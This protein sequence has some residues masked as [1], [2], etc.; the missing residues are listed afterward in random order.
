[1]ELLAELWSP[2]SHGALPGALRLL[3]FR[4]APRLREPSVLRIDGA[5][6]SN[7][8][9][10]RPWLQ[11]VLPMLKSTRRLRLTLGFGA[12]IRALE[13]RLT[14]LRAQPPAETDASSPGDIARTAARLLRARE[15]LIT[16]FGGLSVAIRVLRDLAG[17][18]VTSRSYRADCAVETDPFLLDLAADPATGPEA[19]ARLAARHPGRA[20]PDLALERA[21]LGE[22]SSSALPPVKDPPENH[23]HGR[24]VG[25]RLARLRGKA[26][27]G[28]AGAAAVLRARY[29]DLARE[30]DAGATW[31]L[32][33][34]LETIRALA[35][36]GEPPTRP[37]QPKRPTMTAPEASSTRAPLGITLWELEHRIAEGQWPDP[38]G[39]TDARRG[40][41]HGLA[42]V[43][44]GTWIT[45]P[46]PGAHVVVRPWDD[47]ALAELLRRGDAVNWSALHE[48]AI[49]RAGDTA[50]GDAAPTPLLLL[51]TP[52][53]S[54]VSSLPES[55][56]LAVLSGA[57]LSHAGLVA[58]GR[59]LAALFQIDP[60]NE[61]L[62]SGDLVHLNKAGRVDLVRAAP[63]PDNSS[64]EGSHAL[65]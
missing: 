62:Q 2:A 1:V 59:G 54:L 42:R 50:R 5:C 49:A 38:E 47:E 36:G 25:A 16:G 56:T 52:E 64:L 19:R 17:R 3:G 37:N 43:K 58:R 26:R 28:L 11:L 57:L 27:V 41:E 8:V 18:R 34:P 51:S 31:A 46:R 45:R 4:V 35:R 20:L 55:W 9:M 48:T 61:Q 23:P 39:S 44:R 63:A 24:R 29:L 60:R 22:A 12:R 40:S 13:E 53:L 65:R 15:D 32:E 14:E 7:H 10:A 33:L 6:Y 30:M 21:R